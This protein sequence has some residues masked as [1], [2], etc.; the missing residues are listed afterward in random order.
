MR[1]FIEDVG[2][3]HGQS[4]KNLGKFLTALRV[5]RRFFG[6]IPEP[7]APKR[8]FA[9]IPYTRSDG[10]FDYEKYRASQV[11]A[12]KHKIDKVWVIEANV[13]YLSDYIR[14]HQGEPR[15][16]L[17]HGTRRGKEQ[18]WFKKYLGCEVIGTEISD[19]ALD[20]PDTIQWDFHEVKPEWINAVDFIYS[21]AF[22][23]S[24]DPEACL[25]AWMSCIRPGGLCLIEHTLKRGPEDAKESD[26]FK[27]ELWVMPYL[28][29][30]WGRGRYG[31]RE[32]LSAPERPK[33]SCDVN[34]IVVSQ[35]SKKW[36]E[37]TL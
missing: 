15:F 20:F 19:T 24:Y 30:R 1:T 14:A 5:A 21:N 18:A 12:N 25:N 29:T 13:A 23:H 17:C 33:P 31:V 11:K 4:A 22:D 8:A 9:L 28:I 37:P 26:P 16:G 6:Q 34:V 32:I 3:A 27:A 36:L 35:F 7:K 10:S 2:F